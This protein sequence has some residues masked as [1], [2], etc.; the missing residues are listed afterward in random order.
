[1]AA[2]L[3]ALRS[4]ALKLIDD[5]RPIDS[6]AAYSFNDSTE[7][8]QAFTTDKAAIKL[9]VLH[10][11]HKGTTALHD[12]LVR[13]TKQISP[14][15]GKKAIVVFTDGAD[16]SSLLASDAAIRA[17]K[18]AGVPVYAMAYGDALKSPVLLANLEAIANA[19]GGLSLPVRDAAEMNSVF[20]RVSHDITHGYLLSF[21]PTAVDKR[22]HA[23]QLVL[24]NPQGRKVRARGGYFPE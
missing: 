11:R 18:E 15:T 21:K 10:I 1:M 22:W 20:A 17:A 19:T 12:A 3:A 7:E 16:N 2:A 14:R 5:L 4:S 24:R 6:V 9:A 23:L 8:L 13:V